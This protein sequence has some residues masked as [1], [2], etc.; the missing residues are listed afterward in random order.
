MVPERCE[1]ESVRRAIGEIEPAVEGVRFVLSIL[2]PSQSGAEKTSEF[3]GVRRL[4]HKRSPRA[5]E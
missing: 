2:Q 4:A 5:S 3:L 1:A